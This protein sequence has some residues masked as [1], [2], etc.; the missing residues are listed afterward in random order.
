M[1]KTLRKRVLPFLCPMLFFISSI[2]QAQE[3]TATTYLSSY[4]QLLEQDFDVKFS[5]IDEDLRP[6]QITI[7]KS[8]KLSEILE[9][10]RDQTQIEIQK[11]SERY[12]TLKKT[13]TVHICAIILD[14][15]ENNTVAGAT[16]EVL[17]SDVAS[18]TDLD[19][20]FSFANVPRS[21]TIQI[22]HIG[23][24]TLFVN[25]EDLLAPNCPTLL[26]AVNYQL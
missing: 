20:K 7:P 2:A 12:Y 6:I 19:G 4:I 1:L 15:F 17:Q 23:Y 18:V 22:R 3:N 5:Y 11:L 21:A 25:V 13:T 26:L 10:I 14:N 24:K 16:V 8:S 9:D